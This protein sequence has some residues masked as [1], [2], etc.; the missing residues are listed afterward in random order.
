MWCHHLL[1]RKWA[2]CLRHKVYL[3]PIYLYT[4]IQSACLWS[5]TWLHSS[6][7]H[8]ILTETQ[9]TESQYKSTTVV[10]V[11][12]KTSKCALGAYT[13]WVAS[14]LSLAN[15]CTQ[16][17][18]HSTVLYW[19]TN[20]IAKLRF[21]AFPIISLLTVSIKLLDSLSE[22]HWRRSCCHIRWSDH[23]KRRLLC[24][25]LQW[26]RWRFWRRRRVHQDISWWS[27]LQSQP[28][29]WNCVSNQFR[30]VP[31]YG[32]SLNA[33]H[34]VW[35]SL[36]GNTITIINTNAF[37]VMFLMVNVIMMHVYIYTDMAFFWMK[38]TN[39]LHEWPASQRTP[40]LLSRPIWQWF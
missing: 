25:V 22:E 39:D 8:S 34:C 15:T 18:N 27:W 36:W 32:H 35:Q 17:H 20:V 37:W 24:L 21:I 4:V 11:G 30:D 13:L 6:G 12:L 14:T 5:I 29:Q 16:R 31:A 28:R 26:H 7:Q 3:L 23:D 38:G 19:V 9:G 10:D 33:W 1:L 2:D 40:M